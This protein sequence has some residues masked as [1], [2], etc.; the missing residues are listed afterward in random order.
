[1]NNYFAALAAVFAVFRYH[2]LPY[3]V[4]TPISQTPT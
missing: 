2:Q 3:E 4:L 1:M